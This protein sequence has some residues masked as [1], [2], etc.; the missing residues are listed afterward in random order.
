M[1]D[2]LQ[3]FASVDTTTPAG[4]SRLLLKDS[5]PQV[6]QFAT[7][8]ALMLYVFRML[9]DVGNQLAHLCLDN[10]HIM[11]SLAASNCHVSKLSSQVTCLSL[12]VRQAL[13]S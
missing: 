13:A 11:S 9:S 8:T 2:S 5:M 7:L 3:T 12:E 10:E 4:V 1:I 6:E